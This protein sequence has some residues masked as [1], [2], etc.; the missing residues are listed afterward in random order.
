MAKL[1]K[2]EVPEEEEKEDFVIG[3]SN[4]QD[5]PIIIPQSSVDTL[6]QMYEGGEELALLALVIY[7]Q[8]NSWKMKRIPWTDEKLMSTFN[9]SKEELDLIVNIL[10]IIKFY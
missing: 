5:I 4:P 2:K 7:L 3:I 10:D 9:I 8:C 6:V 1:I